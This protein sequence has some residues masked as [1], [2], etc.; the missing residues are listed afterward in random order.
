VIPLITPVIID[1]DITK[2][3][4]SRGNPPGEGETEMIIDK[5]RFA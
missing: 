4:Q 2:K 1:S 3:D 5:L